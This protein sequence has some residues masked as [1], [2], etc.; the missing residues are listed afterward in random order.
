MR[1]VMKPLEHN[2]PVS[3]LGSDLEA[4]VH[5]LGGETARAESITR[6]ASPRQPKAHFKLTLEDGRQFK[7][8]RYESQDKRRRVTDLAPLLDGLPFSRIVCAQG[9]ATLEEWVEGTPLHATAVTERQAGHAGAL[10]GAVHAR[11]GIPEDY[12][13][14][15]PG[16]DEQL[17]KISSHLDRISRAAEKLC[18]LCETLEQLAYELQP[19]SIESGLIHAD[20]CADNMI[21]TEDG[22]LVVVDNEDLRV[23]PLDYDLARCWSRWPM[24]E[25]QRDAFCE[26]YKQHR[27]LDTFMNNRH[28]WAIRALALSL[29]VHLK[30]GRSNQAVLL[31]LQRLAAGDEDQFWPRLAVTNAS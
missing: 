21:V 1:E 12:R 27:S 29:A 16:M 23:G 22:N 19:S 3:E 14:G 10:L 24:T 8:R 9:R 20:F 30:H 11:T 31:S 7:A 5:R 4:L 15:S 18:G 13:S 6:L 2:T 26:G 28:F 17:Q 25:S